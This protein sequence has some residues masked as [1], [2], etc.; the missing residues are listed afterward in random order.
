MTKSIVV[1]ILLLAA[2]SRVLAADDVVS[3]DGIYIGAS[4]GRSNLKINNLSGVSAAD[5]DGNDVAFRLFGGI[6]P[7]DWIGFEAAYVNFGHPDDDVLGERIDAHVSG[8]SGFA[9]GFLNVGSVDLI[10][11]LGAMNW[12][13]NFTGGGLDRRGTGLAYGVGA[14]FRF[15]GLNARIE[16]EG[17][18]VRGVD[19]LNMISVGFTYTFL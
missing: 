10:G 8:I 7:L 1:V 17:F 13:S 12:D 4:V 9:V 6:R 2:S 3:D 5:F 15:F 16:Y 14:Q 18:D 11:K 19:D